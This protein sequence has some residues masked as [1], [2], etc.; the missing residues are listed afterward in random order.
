MKKI[1]IYRLERRLSFLV[2][3]LMP[4]IHGHVVLWDMYLHEKSNI[5]RKLI[6]LKESQ[7]NKTLND[8]S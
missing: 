4:Y 8:K 7:L 6:S 2:L 1:Q 5:I 3:K